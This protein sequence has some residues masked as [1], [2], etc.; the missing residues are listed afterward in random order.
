MTKQVAAKK[1]RADKLPSPKQVLARKLNWDK[2]LLLGAAGNI[3]TI[4]MEIVRESAKLKTDSPEA[5]K[6]LTAA[7]DSLEL[8]ILH[9]EEACKI[10]LAACDSPIDNQ[11]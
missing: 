5:V 11:N 8:A 4:R 1:V 9:W 10:L 7:Q 3:S 2:R 6:H